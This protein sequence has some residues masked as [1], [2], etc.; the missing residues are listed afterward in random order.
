MRAMA[1][2]GVIT[3]LMLAPEKGEGPSGQPIHKK[4]KSLLPLH[5]FILLDFFLVY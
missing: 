1:V 3:G 5:L 2:S 4:N